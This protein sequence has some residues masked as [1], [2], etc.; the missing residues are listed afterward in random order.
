MKSVR[1]AVCAAAIVALAATLSSCGNSGAVEASQGK[2]LPDSWAAIVKQAKKEGSVTLYLAEAN[3]EDR[4]KVG[5]EKAYPDIHLT[6]LRQPSGDLITKLGAEKMSGASGGDVVQL[7]DYGWFKDNE[8]DLAP[9]KGPSAHLYTDAVDPVGGENYI[10]HNV[11]QMNIVSNPEVL[12]SV[13]AHP[14]KTWQDL[15]Q[16]QLKGLVGLSNPTQLPIASQLFYVL[17]NELGPDFFNELSSNG[18][19]LG[20]SASTLYQSVA[21]GDLAAAIGGTS[22]T[23][24]PLVAAGAPIEEADPD[25]P[26]F[27]MGY[28]TG[29]PNWTKHPAAAQVLLE[30]MIS[31]AGQTSM[32]NWGVSGSVL[33]NIQGALQVPTNEIY[34]GD[35]T[36]EQQVYEKNVFMPM[37]S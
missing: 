21:A 16:P 32:N 13:G 30:W 34:T 37:F 28:A 6:I 1:M 18:A 35:L 10:T 33:P 22:A 8:K 36:P 27:V 2:D 31:E 9:A 5:F 23:A 15:L 24:Q 7:S 4:V 20:D 29:I 11:V 12:K 25:D 26:A 14:I 17:N 3:F 19:R